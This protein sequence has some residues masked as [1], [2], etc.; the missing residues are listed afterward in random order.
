MQYTFLAS[1]TQDGNGIYT[2]K[3]TSRGRTPATNAKLL[4]G[5]HRMVQTKGRAV[6]CRVCELS[7]PVYCNKYRV[8][9]A[10]LHLLSSQVAQRT[11]PRP[12]HPF[13]P[14]LVVYL[15]TYIPLTFQPLFSFFS[16]HSLVLF[17]FFLS[18][19]SC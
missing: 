8:L 6:H 5:L 7:W 19:L 17:F 2:A 11:L 14:M 1:S 4:S 10:T 18:K 9:Q 15:T 12:S 16:S 13:T 3:N